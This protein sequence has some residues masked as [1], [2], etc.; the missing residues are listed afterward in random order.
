LGDVEVHDLAS[1]EVGGP[2]RIFL[3]LCGE[4]PTTA[5]VVTD[6]NGLFGL[7]VDT[8]RMMRI[9]AL[10][11]PLL[12]VGIGYPDAATIADT[13]DVR[14]RDLTPTPSRHFDGSGGADAFLR[15]VRTELFPWLDGRLPPAAD[16]I[17]FGHSL[18]GLFGVH[19]LLSE[20]DTFD[21]YILS[22]PSLWWDHHVI[23][24][25]EAQRAAT[26]D[27]LVAAVYVGIGAFETDE[28]RR[29][30]AVNLPVG[31]RA[32]PGR[33]HLDMVAD[34]LRFT[35]ALRGHS[36]PS[37]DLA[38]RVFPDEF[39]ATVPAVVLSHGLR[40]FAGPAPM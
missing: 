27:D 33:T 40:H 6:A 4:E 12:V 19:A 28:G 9:P 3:G 37:L 29:R 21:R 15:F 22:S 38:C 20:P 1:T 30:E 7:T 5:L 26:H 39:H 11:P 36:Y 35:E 31:H 10:L 2:L 8:V 24:E 18:G 32:K 14:V 34:A 23:F 17:F 13:A 16:R 25:R